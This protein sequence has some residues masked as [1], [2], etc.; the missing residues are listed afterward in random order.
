[1]TKHTEVLIEGILSDGSGGTSDRG[2]M[3]ESEII[4]RVNRLLTSYPRVAIVFDYPHG[5]TEYV[6]KEIDERFFL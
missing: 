5:E 3:E 4:Q 1:M 6:T 2:D